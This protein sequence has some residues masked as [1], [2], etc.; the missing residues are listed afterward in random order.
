MIH[1]KYKAISPARGL[2]G[3]CKLGT[4]CPS[5]VS[6]DQA[7]RTLTGGWRR[8]HENP[9]IACCP[10][11]FPGGD[12]LHSHPTQPSS[13]T[14]AFSHVIV[15]VT[16]VV[17]VCFNYLT[18]KSEGLVM[19]CLS[20]GLLHDGSIRGA[21]GLWFNIQASFLIENTFSSPSC[22][23][24]GSAHAE[25]DI[26]LH[27]IGNERLREKPNSISVRYVEAKPM[28]YGSRGASCVHV[29]RGALSSL[30]ITAAR[31]ALPPPPVPP[32]Q[33]RSSD[34]L[35]SSQALQK[36]TS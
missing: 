10:G 35:E 8:L 27:N 23:W 29:E 20:G 11:P 16:V 17:M 18:V 13:D 19:Q 1:K 21:V 36:L 26:T 24:F 9:N 12:S 4:Q 34:G 31:P 6:M 14:Q 25:K 32:R 3:I 28:I 30:L 7:L 15:E 33:R 22:S 2:K 5:Q